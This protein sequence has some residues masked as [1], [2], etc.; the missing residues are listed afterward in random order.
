MIRHN[1]RNLVIGFAVGSLGLALAVTIPNAFTSGAVISSSAVNANFTA[2]KTAVDALEAKQSFGFEL[3]VPAGTTDQ[4]VVEN[5]K[6]NGD[7]NW[8]VTVTLRYQGEGYADVN[9]GFGVYYV[10][11]G[12]GAGANKWVVNYFKVGQNLSNRKFFVTAIRP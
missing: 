1:I 2:L 3:T 10:N 7:P 5:P 8:I 11:G 6:L 4:F 12:G 9:Q